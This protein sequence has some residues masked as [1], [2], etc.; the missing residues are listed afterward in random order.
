[1]AGTYLK[2]RALIKRILPRSLVRGLVQ[3]MPDRTVTRVVP[4]V[5]GTLA[6]GLRRHHWLM[7]DRCFEGHGLT[8]GLFQH[9]AREGDVFYD[10]GA[11]I[12]Y[13]ARWSLANLPIRKLVAFE[14]MAANLT[15]L[16]KNRE[17]AKRQ[18]DFDIHDLALSDQD[19]DAELQTDDQSDGS[20]ALSRV[21]GGAASESRAVRGL[22]PLV[23]TV[24]ERRL[25]TL[26]AEAPDLPPP[27]LMKVDTE[28]AEHLVLAGGRETFATHKPRLI[29]AMHGKDRAEESLSLLAD[30]GYHVAGWV[31][32]DAERQWQMFRPGDAA[33]M[34]DNNCVA[35]FDEADVA[36]PAPVLD[37][38]VS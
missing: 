34:S 15:I 24:T 4:H 11:N 36:T 31:G 7:S 9:M 12:G 13:Y 21:T 37:L 29:L 6:F 23:E 18:G 33:L 32:K 2:A 38:S 27:S 17:L 8:L 1:M 20:A 26:L 35:A 28:G 3:R 16:R 25:D 22:A 10:V 30:V 14:P 5:D 19:G